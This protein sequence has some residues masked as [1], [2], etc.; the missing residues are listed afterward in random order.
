MRISGIV[1]AMRAVC[2]LPLRFLSRDWVAKHFSCEI[3]RTR[4]DRALKPLRKA[5]PRLGGESR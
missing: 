1:G 2:R 3:H 4:Q 5:R